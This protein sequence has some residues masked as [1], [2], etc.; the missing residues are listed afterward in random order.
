M[1]FIFV[2]S[3]FMSKSGKI[4]CPVENPCD[5]VLAT[6]VMEDFD[7]TKSE[8]TNISSE[9]NGESESKPSSPKPEG[10]NLELNLPSLN[11]EMCFGGNAPGNLTKV[12]SSGNN[13]QPQGDL[14]RKFLNRR[15]KP[16][17]KMKGVCEGLNSCNSNEHFAYEA[18]NFKELR[19]Q[20]ENF[21]T[22]WL[23]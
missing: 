19:K 1:L 3:L 6:P 16:A 21:V 4:A 20:Y 18:L 8:V 11:T 10:L 9:V 15:R 12:C 17:V 14:A 13:T 2:A 7:N 5:P 22:H 23:N